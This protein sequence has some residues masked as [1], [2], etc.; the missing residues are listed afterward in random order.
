MVICP[1]RRG[2]LATLFVCLALGGPSLAQ[3]DAAA[4]AGRGANNP[5]AAAEAVGQARSALKE[6]AFPWYD[7]ISDRVRPIKLRDAPRPSPSRG[8]APAAPWKFGD[9]LVFGGFVLALV[10]LVVLVV[11][12]WERFEPK[13]ATAE[14]PGRVPVLVEGGL[15]LPA[16]LR[17]GLATS[18]PWSEANRRRLAGDYAGAVVCLFAH[19]LLVLGRLGLVRLAPGRTGRQLHRAVADRD[20]QGLMLPT[21][22]QFEAVYYGH[23]V[24][25]EGD[26]ATLW[27]SAEAFERRAAVTQVAG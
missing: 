3:D 16:E 8:G 17:G 15:V 23:K 1:A 7:P 4:S 6:G 24:P 22:R 11:R 9:Y 2:S 19:Q 10:I 13:E 18:D 20:F 26:F 5:Q 27:T 14:Y 21:L 25:S 12:Y